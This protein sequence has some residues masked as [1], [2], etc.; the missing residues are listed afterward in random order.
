GAHLPHHR[1]AGSTYTVTFRLADS[2]P[3]EVLKAWVAERDALRGRAAREELSDEEVKRLEALQSEKVQAYLDAGYGACWLRREDIAGLVAEALTYHE[4]KRYRLYAWCVMPNHVHAE[5][6][7]LPGYELSDI[8][9]SWKSFT[10]NKANAL[11][12]R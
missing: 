7:P 6:E 8:L 10:A 9:H 3:Q 12:G 1:R 4:G 2:V 5:V 11:L